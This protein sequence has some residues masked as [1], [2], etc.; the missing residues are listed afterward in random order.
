MKLLDCTLRDGGYYTNW[1]FDSDLVDNYI[2][3]FNHLPVDYLEV[4]YRSKPQDEYLGEYFY[5]PVYVL[6]RLKEQSNKK[7]AIILNEKAVPKTDAEDL[8]SPCVGLIDMIRIA[9]KPENFERA[10]GLGEEVKRLGFDVSFNVMYM[11]EWAG[12]KDLM[13]L[14]P[15]L[16]GVVDYLYMVDSY[17]GVF[18]KEVKNTI[19][20]LRSKTNV[21]LGFHGH[22]NLE[23]G[24]A[25]TLAAIEEGV[26]IVDATIT[27]MGR[28][29]GN[30][31]M[32]LL[33]TVLN[34]KGKLDF[35][36]NWLSK[37]TDP[38]LELQKEYGWGTNLPY[39]VSGANSIPQKQV[40]EW[41][42]KRYYSFNS[43]IRAL[44]NRS[45]GFKDNQRLPILNFSSEKNYKQALIVGGGPNAVKHSDGLTQ[46][47]KSNHDVVLI[48]ASSKNALSFLNVD[49]D[50]YF[51]LVG[52][53]GYRLEDTFKGTD[54]I[55]GKC[56]LPPYP[57]EMGTYVPTKLEHNAF[58]LKNVNL[59]EDYKDSHTALALQTALSLNVN[60]IF[61]AGYDGYSDH[62]MGEKEQALFK[63]NEY[64]FQCG[65][66]QLGKQIVS[67]TPTKYN[68]LKE[69]SV[70]SLL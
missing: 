42:S 25:N 6:E 30:L 63:E 19:E 55:N 44:E 16:D 51:C 38:F 12:N 13:S 65:E 61:V 45:K 36:Y 62:L 21:K 9:V 58:E 49:N 4:G 34:S 67:L 40:M 20:L 14:M 37:V 8:L 2:E 47:L 52:N 32:E 59:T 54:E 64:L 69:Y 48:H 33:L 56:I 11:S 57:R 43:I 35:D 18:P 10:I 31:K 39:M 60:D 68:Q 24:L 27:G 15:K 1:D 17:G 29:A 46:F 66:E 5:C 22:D 23:M 3:A 50:Q 26:D 53:E 7:L 70:Y 28:G 41:V